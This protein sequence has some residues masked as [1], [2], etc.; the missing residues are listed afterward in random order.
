MA[1]LCKQTF[2]AEEFSW[3]HVVQATLSREKQLRTCF[4]TAIWLTSC[5]TF[6]LK[7]C[8]EVS[9]DSFLELFNSWWAGISL[10][11]QSGVLKVLNFALHFMGNLD[12]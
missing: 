7:F 11:E 10:K 8:K 1:Y 12:D 6:L 9:I 2:K 4:F 3:L 5:G